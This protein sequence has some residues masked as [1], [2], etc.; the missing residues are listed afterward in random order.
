M[1]KTANTA[2]E[3]GDHCA[4]IRRRNGDCQI[5]LIIDVGANV[6]DTVRRYLTELIMFIVCP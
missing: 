3:S 1:D 6:G 4:E 5:E 2:S